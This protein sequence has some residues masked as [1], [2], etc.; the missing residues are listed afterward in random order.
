MSNQ[1]RHTARLILRFPHWTVLVLNNA[2]GILR[3]RD[4]LVSGQFTQTEEI[5]YIAWGLMSSG[6]WGWLGV[7]QGSARPYRVISG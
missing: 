7:S 5:V 3:H 4:F 1:R 2:V 6:T